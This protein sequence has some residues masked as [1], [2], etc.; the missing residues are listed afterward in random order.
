M[1]ILF[2]AFWIALNGRLTMEIFCF[3]L[4][5]SDG[6]S[7][8]FWKFLD[9]KPRYDWLLIT[10]LP[11]LLRSILALVRE[12]VLATL[13]MAGFIFNHRDIPEPVLVSFTA[14]LK[15]ELAWTILADSITLTP[16][17]ITVDMHDGQ[18]QVHCYDRSL[19]QGIDDSVFVRLLKRWEESI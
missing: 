8:F 14:P 10:S 18:F 19:A 16:G 12:V 13:C 6:A 9:Y 15:T 4:A 1:S 5:I 2:F 17:T 11:L 3:G 7:W